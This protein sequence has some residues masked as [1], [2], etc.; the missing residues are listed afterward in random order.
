MK[1]ALLASTAAGG[2]LLFF[3][4]PVQAQETVPN[5]TVTEE[6]DLETGVIIVTAQK[7]VQAVTDVP[8]SIT[9]FTEEDLDDLRVTE[10]TDYARL[11]PNIAFNN[12]SGNRSDV[13]F[14]I[15]GVGP[16]SSGGSGNSVGIYV[17]EFNIAPNILARTIDTELQDAARIE[18]L[19][20]PQGTFFGRNTVGGAISITSVKPDTTGFHGYA[21]AGYSSFDTYRAEAAVNIP[22]GET[23]AARVLGY[24]DESDGFLIQEGPFDEGNSS[25]NYGGRVALRFEPGPGT[26][27]DLSGY[28]SNQQ[29]TL[30][31][32][33]P[34]GF[35]SNGVQLL[36]DLVSGVAGRRLGIS[37]LAAIIGAADPLPDGVFPENERTINTDIGLP[38]ENETYTAIGRFEQDLGNDLRFTVVGGYIDNSFFQSGEGDFTSNSSFTITQ[39]VDFEAY[40]LEAR[41]SGTTERLTYLVGGFYGHDEANV[42]NLTENLP[43]DPFTVNPIPGVGLGAYPFAFFCIGG[44]SGIPGCPRNAVPGFQRFIPGLNSSTGLFENVN[45]GNEVESFAGFFDATYEVG[46]RLDLSFGGRYTHETVSGFRIEGPL[47]DPF[48][49]RAS[50]PGTEASFDDFSPRFAAVYELSDAVSL[51]GAA[52]RG[53][54]SGGA[55]PVADDPA[56]PVDESVFEQES[57][58]NYEVGAKVSALRGRVY[59]S[60]ALFYMDWTDI[61]IRAQDPLTQRQ[62]IQ[63][64]PGATNQ[65]LEFELAVEPAEGLSLG[66][67]YGY[68]DATFDEFPNAR[69][70]DGEV[71][72]A[73]GNRLPNSPANTISGVAR[74]EFPISS[75]FDLFTQGEAS[76]IDEQQ[77]DIADNARR[78]SDEYTIV[79]LRAGVQSEAFGVQLFVE[80]LFDEVY[81]FGTNNL[82]TYLSGAQAVVG[83]SRRYGVQAT[84][85]F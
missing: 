25:E 22:L 75:R 13:R 3:G 42:V 34:T 32:F 41:I 64:A 26:T 15:R 21:E 23:F 54:R 52:S 48:A 29:Q 18:I 36:T 76:F 45:F 16:I 10:F 84:V 67:N 1:R 27:F 46:D 72:D 40:S 80:N 44:G 69:T 85:R 61:Q 6:D 77:S 56:T 39:D 20:G 51:Y 83:E 81:R 33:V 82:E 55:N 9:I 2:W 7:R 28:Y 47:A 66:F 70:L 49:P 35:L 31:S 73:S 68:V 60:L 71:I 37:D 65:G 43:S 14:S 59:A 4:S 5:L 30:P 8:I 78:R 79:N 62:I 50:N 24:Y 17:D 57:I 63:N 19:R 38:S 58:W 11:T 53:F 12:P 74:Y